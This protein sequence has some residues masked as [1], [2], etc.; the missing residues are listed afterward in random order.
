MKKLLL[1]SL[2]LISFVTSGQILIDPA[3]S[4]TT[5]RINDA[6][7][8]SLTASGTDNYLV[9]ITGTFT[10]SSTPASASLIDKAVS[11]TFTNPNTGASTLDFDGLGVRNI[12]KWS[13]GSLVALSAGDLTGTI[14]IRYDGT[15]WVTEG[16]TGGTAL[17]FSSPLSE[18]GGVVKFGGELTEE[19]TEVNI[20][21]DGV[22]DKTLDIYSNFNDGTDYESNPYLKFGTGFNQ[23]GV[24]ST[25]DA[26]DI[27]IKG[28]QTGVNEFSL[29]IYDTRAGALATGLEYGQDLSSTLGLL[30]VPHIGY[31]DAKYWPRLGGVTVSG[32]YSVG[33]N[34][35][36]LGTGSSI[37]P[38]NS[39]MAHTS[40]SNLRTI[41]LSSRP[42]LSTRESTISAFSDSGT[43]VTGINLTIDN[44]AGGSPSIKG[45]SYESNTNGVLVSDQIN[46]TGLY[47]HGDY[48]TNG[49]ANRGNRWIPDWGAVNTL[50]SEGGP[51]TGPAGG[52]LAGTYPNPTI[53]SNI[54]L[55]GSASTTTQTANKYDSTIATTEYVDRESNII[56]QPGQTLD[57]F[58]DSFTEGSKETSASKRYP[59]VLSV[60]LGT[61]LSNQGVPGD[62]VWNCFKKIVQTR[63]ANANTNPAT[64]MIGLN[65][66]VRKQ[67]APGLYK[68]KAGHKAILAH[69]FSKTAVAANNGSVSTTGTWTTTSGG[70]LND[71]ASFG[72][73]GLVRTSSVA[74]STLTYSFTGNNLIIGTWGCDITH[75][76][77]GRF[78]VTIDGILVETY[79]PA[80][81]GVY[82]TNLGTQEGGRN[83][84]VLIYTTLTG[85]TH[86]VVITTLDNKPTLIDYFGTLN[87][88]N[89]CTPVLVGGI[90]YR[91]PTGYL[92]PT[93]TYP[94]GSDLIWDGANAKI[95]EA[96]NSFPSYPVAYV[97]TNEYWIP[98]TGEDISSDDDTHPTDSGAGHI[99]AAFL[100]NINTIN[101]NFGSLNV[102]NDNTTASAG[103]SAQFR[104]LST[105]GN[106]IAQF[107]N[108]LNKVMQIGIYGSA[109]SLSGVLASGDGYVTSNSDSK[110]IYGT[111][112]TVGGARSVIAVG[113]YSSATS[114]KQSTTSAGTAFGNFTATSAVH[115]PAGTATAG[116]GP[117]KY[118]SGTLLTAPESGVVEFN[119]AHYLTNSALNRLGL[120][121][122]I[123][124]F[125]TAVSN[126]S[127]TET[128]LFTYNTKGSTLVST[129][130]EIEFTGTGT[131]NDL[132]ATA[133]I[134]F[135][136]AGTLCGDTGAL[137][138]S[139]IGGFTWTF[140]VKRTGAATA[141]TSLTITTP[142]ASTAQY[143]SKTDLSGLT[144]GGNNIIKITG[145]AAGASGGTGD[146][147]ASI[148]KIIWWP[149]AAN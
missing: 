115:F 130:Q 52:G 78:T 59:N 120:A 114:I 55:P 147:T 87:A 35:L 23:F 18:T 17:T 40:S 107:R 33:S 66:I 19:T 128:D 109:V 14:R 72:L 61:L 118:T 112:S 65:D 111:S 1:I 129:E 103:V 5:I 96:L 37:T 4:P 29:K 28:E 90:L 12:L 44:N 70:S 46:S 124:G 104:A 137:T 102:R 89:A 47:Y 135:Y 145:T 98:V 84:D 110:V 57:N 71:K 125:S 106:T 24:R 92:L 121:G 20:N 6:L 76:D 62:G 56:V 27:S 2:V 94:A 141:T 67:D 41:R 45:F 64:I 50:V 86:S 11:V 8:L 116:T 80:N 136:F 74:G 100:K 139:A 43:G 25:S 126:T 49:I 149:A 91:S 10:Y 58:G 133:Q 15:Q 16:G 119:N 68:L 144:F 54:N 113:D 63:V 9:G 48:S 73:G 123:A 75:Y 32:N 132:T 38:L 22:T 42:S 127:T 146:I 142:G 148:G 99:A 138:I 21:E 7:G 60:A 13:S 101:P 122:K 30:S 34:S 3:T 69:L 26:S 77:D 83:H 131:L 31:N 85:G 95:R 105:S 97:N 134:R 117:T 53:A 81:K 93:P 143:T 51:P 88:P 36:F 140:I 79:D 108:D 39:Y 82:I